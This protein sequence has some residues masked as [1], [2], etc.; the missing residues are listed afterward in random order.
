MTPEQDWGKCVVDALEAAFGWK[1]TDA[2]ALFDKC[3]VS[4]GEAFDNEVAA[5]LFAAALNH[6][7]LRS[8]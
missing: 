1:R 3:W 5:D 8:N 2:Q 7:A 6:K 4:A